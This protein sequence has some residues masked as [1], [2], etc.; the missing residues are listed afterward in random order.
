MKLNVQKYGVDFYQTA[1]FLRR[2]SSIVWSLNHQT[3]KTME[4]PCKTHKKA[5]QERSMRDY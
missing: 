1:L 2:Y 3:F 5:T 4:S